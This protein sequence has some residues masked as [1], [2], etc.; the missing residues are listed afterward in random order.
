MGDNQGEKSGMPCLPQ[1]QGNRCSLN[2]HLMIMRWLASFVP[3][4]I[5]AR[6]LLLYKW[7]V[8]ED[9]EWIVERQSRTR[10]KQ[11]EQALPEREKM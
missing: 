10:E 5:D 7:Y 8:L 2:E 3:M 11:R 4:E 1:R 6:Q 9:I